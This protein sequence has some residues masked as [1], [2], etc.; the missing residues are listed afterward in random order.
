ML[1]YVISTAGSVQNATPESFAALW[2]SDYEREKTVKK[3]DETGKVSA[4][5][6]KPNRIKPHLARGVGLN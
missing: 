5:K 2:L 3:K 6:V 1:N 4:H